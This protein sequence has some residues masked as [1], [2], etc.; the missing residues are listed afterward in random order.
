MEVVFPLELVEANRED[1]ERIHAVHADSEYDS[2]TE[3]GNAN[4]TRSCQDCQ[5]TAAAH[6]RGGFETTGFYCWDCLPGPTNTS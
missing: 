2:V 6:V 4:A 1:I 5:D 3:L